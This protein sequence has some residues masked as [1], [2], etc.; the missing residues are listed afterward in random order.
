MTTPDRCAI[1]S[2]EFLR[3]FGFESLKELPEIEEI[4]E[5]IAEDE[6]LDMPLADQISLDE[7]TD[8]DAAGPENADRADFEQ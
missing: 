6:E 4:D 2:L 1:R 8:L 5:I 3:L 7:A